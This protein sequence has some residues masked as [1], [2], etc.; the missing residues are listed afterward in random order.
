MKDVITWLFVAAL[1]GLP[2]ISC[3]PPEAKAKRNID[4]A[5]AVT[6]SPARMVKVDRTIPVVGTLFPKDDATLGAQ[7]EG[8]VERTMAEFGDRLTNGQIIAQIDTT[9]YEAM[10][11]QAAANSARAKASALNTE[12]NLKRTRELNKNSIA[13]SSEL[14]Q[15]IAAAEQSAA[16]VKAAEAAEA[17]ARLNL[18]RS[19]VRAPFDAAVAERI[20]SA[21]DFMKVGSPLFRIVNDGV[22]KYIVQAPERYAGDV[23]KEQLVRF[24]VDAYPGETFEGR[25]YLIS[26]SVNTTTRGFA[27][28]A[29]VDNRE[30]RLKA[31]SFAR[32]ELLLE[33]GASVPMVP[34]DAVINFAGVTKVFIIDNDVARSRPVQ[35]GR[36]RDGLQEILAGV[37]E[38]EQVAVTGQTKLFDG[39]RVRLKQSLDGKAT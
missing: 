13:S 2:G 31:S 16:E 4:T 34:I 22:L 27:F 26:P 5:V 1:C 23:R 12:Q 30:G 38:G 15:A 35:V 39:A 17:M 10:A 25:V 18:E 24:T 37:K 7:V 36:I 28:G 6:V 9:T 33:K 3:S 32:G 11:R 14:D 29:L 21:G 19:H 8:K 20:A